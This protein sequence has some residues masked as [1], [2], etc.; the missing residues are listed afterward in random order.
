MTTGTPTP[1]LLRDTV[2]SR[3]AAVASG[4]GSC[5]SSC[6]ATCGCDESC[7]SSSSTDVP[8]AELGYS[9]ADL[10]DLPEGSNLGLGCGNPAGLLTLCTGEVVLDLGSGGGIDCFIAG[11]RVGPEGHVIGVDMTAEMVSR[12]RAQADHAGVT[13]VEFRLGELEHLPV[14]DGSVDVVISNCVMNLV[15]D[16]AQA[17]REAFRVLRP[18]GRLA[19]ADVVA[20]HPLSEQLRNDAERWASCSSGARS[21]EEVTSTLRG[22]GFVDVSVETPRAGTTPASLQ[23]QEKIGVVSGSIRAT[24]PSLP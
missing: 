21:P 8:G 17:Y 23:P 15:P 10:A 11:R 2:R 5:C 7:C 22:L 16:Q 13:N 1:E 4:K 20:L 24:K 19:V 14:A 18:G 12:A 9:E 6:D 3:Y